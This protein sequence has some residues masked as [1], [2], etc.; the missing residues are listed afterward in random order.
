MNPDYPSITETITE[1]TNISEWSI[2]RGYCG[3]FNS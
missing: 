2:G 1:P 3:T